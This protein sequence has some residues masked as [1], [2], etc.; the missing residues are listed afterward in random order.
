[1]F[2]VIKN[3]F[4]QAF[5]KYFLAV[6]FLTFSTLAVANAGS[7]YY[8]YPS[9][10]MQT[11]TKTKLNKGALSKFEKQPWYKRFWRWIK[12]QFKR[13]LGKVLIV[14]TLWIV[15]TVVSAIY[16]EMVKGG[17]KNNK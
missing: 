16:K 15:I 6:M 9:Q 8:R 12:A 14:G 1:M 2:I 13:L 3:Y 7:S 10:P 5:M 11:A 4:R 17:R